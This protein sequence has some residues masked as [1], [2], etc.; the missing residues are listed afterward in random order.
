MLCVT[1]TFPRPWTVS[2]FILKLLS[3]LPLPSVSV[4]IKTAILQAVHLLLGITSSPHS[5]QS[6]Y[7]A[8]LALL[9]TKPALSSLNETH[10]PLVMA[11][12][13]LLFHLNL[14][15]N[16][17]AVVLL[18]HYAEGDSE[19]QQMVLEY[20]I[21]HGMVDPWGYF[22]SAMKMIR[23]KQTA[24]AVEEEEEEEEEEA[25]EEMVVVVERSM[26]NKWLN[27][28]AEE[29]AIVQHS[30]AAATKKPSK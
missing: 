28:W 3:F 18:H 30:Q 29:L 2:S 25:E 1:Q 9:E 10:R 19:V 24:G 15:D 27:S 5:T 23:T 14:M 12:L 4:A 21:K 6:I 7:E 20:L 11:A 8:V 22:N 16:R 13:K 26:V 17:L